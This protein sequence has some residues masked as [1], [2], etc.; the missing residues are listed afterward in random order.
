VATLFTPRDGQP[1]GPKS[2]A[3]INPGTGPDRQAALVCEPGRWF[4]RGFAK[5]GPAGNGE[6]PQSLSEKGAWLVED[7]TAA[8]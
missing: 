4:F 7:D 3:D 2:N 1:V 5:A 6:K 8:L